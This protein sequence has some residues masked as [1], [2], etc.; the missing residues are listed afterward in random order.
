MHTSVTEKLLTR[1]IAVG[2]GFTTVFIVSGSVTDPVNVTKQLSL[3]VTSAMAVGILALGGVHR[4][5]LQSRTLWLFSGL[6]LASGLSSILM[7]A[8]PISQGIYGSYGRNNG[9]LTYLLLVGLLLS[10]IVLSK[11]ESISKLILWLILNL[12]FL[13]DLCSAVKQL[14]CFRC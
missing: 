14:E 9:F 12:L 8:S 3:G 11:R 2:S 1:I 6:F 7:S 4:A 5:F 13:L 10:T